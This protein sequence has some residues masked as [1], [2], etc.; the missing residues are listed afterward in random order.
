[1][2]WRWL[3]FAMFA[4]AG[5]ALPF[6]CNRPHN[7]ASHRATASACPSNRP[8]GSASCLNNRFCDADTQCEAGTNGR[9]NTLPQ[10]VG[11][12][13]DRCT[14]DECFTD[15]DCGSGRACLCGV[16]PLWSASVG[17]SCVYAECRIDADCA[18]GYQCSLSFAPACGT[19]PGY[20]CHT[21]QDTCVDSTDCP[22][23]YPCAFDGTK[24]ACSTC[25]PDA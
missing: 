22:S 18:D 20:A 2:S 5:V 25:G 16:D 10:I 3:P 12:C 8:P 1:M 19:S 9:C 24:W 17:N 15:D 4:I 11:M 23:G 14:Y 13:S 21:S 7:A 6:A